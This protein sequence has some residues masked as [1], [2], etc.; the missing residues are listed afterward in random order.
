ME[1]KTPHEADLA[2]QGARAA[3]VIQGMAALSAFIA[4]HPDLPLEQYGV[5]FQF[6]VR[7]G[8]DEEERAE[9]DRI[10]RILGVTADYTSA[11][12]THYQA[13][14]DFGGGIAY[15]VSAITAEYMKRFDASIRRQASRRPKAAQ[16][17]AA[18]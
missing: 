12:R 18:A 14:R 15:T 17:G 4:A 10:A 16:N 6:S 9:V 2:A 8:T 5:P 1:G 7:T 13:R 3:E 11:T